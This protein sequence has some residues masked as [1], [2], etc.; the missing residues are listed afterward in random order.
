MPIEKFV[1]LGMNRGINFADRN[2]YWTFPSE[3]DESSG[4][5]LESIDWLIDRK[6]SLSKCQILGI[7]FG[8]ERAI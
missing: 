4:S 3:I 5:Y 6:F 1:N 7:N 8:E 2:V